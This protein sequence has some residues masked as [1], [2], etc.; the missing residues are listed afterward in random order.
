LLSVAGA[1]LALL[2]T[3]AASWAA[4]PGA[5]GRVAYSETRGLVPGGGGYNWEIFTISPAGGSPSRLT[6][7]AIADTQPSWSADGR[8][9]VFIR[10]SAAI[11]QNQN[12][13]IMRADGTHKRQVTNWP[14]P[15]SSPSFSPHGGRIVMTHGWDIGGDIVSVW[16]SPSISAWLK[17]SLDE[18]AVYPY[19]LSADQVAAH[20]AARPSA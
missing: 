15:E 9:L 18:V 20:A 3:A 4:F 1:V 10:G 5:N 2:A 14:G 8:R 12:V 13:W 11:G 19:P 6:D 7:N 16:P 17:S